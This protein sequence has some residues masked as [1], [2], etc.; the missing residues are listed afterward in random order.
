MPKKLRPSG[1]YGLLKAS[2]LKVK[3]HTTHFV[4]AG[5]GEN[6]ITLIFITSWAV[7]IVA[8]RQSDTAPQ[9]YAQFTHRIHLSILPTSDISMLNIL[10]LFL[11]ILND[12]HSMLLTSAHYFPQKCIT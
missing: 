12:P 2:T 9:K 7:A 5:F 11:A 3:Y 10:Q 1:D 8:V 6:Y 4:M